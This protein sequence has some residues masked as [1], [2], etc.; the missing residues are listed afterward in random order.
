MPSPLVI[1]ASA[2]VEL[3]IAS[4]LS[5]RIDAAIG[6]RELIAPEL[7]GVEALQSLRGLERGGIL[8]A[9]RA[10][11][12]VERLLESRIARV[13]T[14]ALLRHAW[15]LRHNLSAYDACYVALARTLSCPLLTTD[16]PLVRAP[17]LG[18]EVLVA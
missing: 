7:L 4:P 2:F 14:R 5:A 10:T 16:G 1:D 11:R 12:A 6:D 3:L 18:V 9:Q 17:G 15:S 13:P 8:T